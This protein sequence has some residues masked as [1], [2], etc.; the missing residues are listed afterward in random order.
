MAAC[1]FIALDSIFIA[2]VSFFTG[3]KFTVVKFII[4]DQFELKDQANTGISFSNKDTT[5]YRARYNHAK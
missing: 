3:Y 2:T 4:N 5:I 1:F